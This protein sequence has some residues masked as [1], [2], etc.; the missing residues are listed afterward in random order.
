VS[1]ILAVLWIWFLR[2]PP[3]QALLVPEARDIHVIK[4]GLG[5]WEL[6][7]R[8]PSSTVP[9]YR[10]VAH[11]LEM[12]GWVA[13]HQVAP[14]I[15]SAPYHPVPPLRIERLVSMILWEEVILEPDLRD[16]TRVRMHI[17]RALRLDWRAWLHALGGVTE[18]KQARSKRLARWI[19]SI[20]HL[21]L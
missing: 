11:Q 16:P 2:R 14:D 1:A 17:H 21:Q 10:K 6:T 15:Y 7:Y 18:A 3:L 19:G 4:H 9:W 12:Q 5:T 13:H 20:L 8:V